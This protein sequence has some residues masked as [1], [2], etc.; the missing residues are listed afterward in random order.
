MERG[1]E[2]NFSGILQWIKTAKPNWGSKGPVELKEADFLAGL[3]E[4]E[5]NELFDALINNDKAETIDAIVDIVWMAM[6]S[7]VRMGITEKELEDGFAKVL[8]SNW[9]KYCMSEEE[10]EYTCTLYGKGEHPNKRGEIIPCYWKQVGHAYVVF[11]STDDKI[12]KSHKFR[13]VSE[14]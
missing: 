9:T 12:M 3:V 14:I 10:A 7:A 11:R 5:K 6:N 4:E 8:E 2:V 1:I 13:D